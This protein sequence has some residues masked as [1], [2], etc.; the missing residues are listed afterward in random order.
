[1][2]A[3]VHR[4]VPKD[5]GVKRRVRLEEPTAPGQTEGLRVGGGMGGWVGLRNGWMVGFKEWVDGWV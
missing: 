3:R 5:I 4:H 1:M 2:P